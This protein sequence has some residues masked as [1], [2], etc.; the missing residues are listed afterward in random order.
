MPL[1]PEEKAELVKDIG[2]AIS[3]NIAEQLK[4]IADQV[5]SLQANHKELAESLTANAKAEEAE[6]REAV[7]AKFGKEV[8]EGLTGNALDALYK[9]T[10]TAAGV[11]N[12]RVADADTPKFDAVPE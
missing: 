12:G 1:T 10:G 4:P 5:E 6:K 3:A 8:A 11:G 2:A 9:Q 7:E